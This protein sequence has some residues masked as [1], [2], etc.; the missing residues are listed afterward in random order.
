M[1][2]E[3]VA[4]SLFVLLVGCP[5]APG[6]DA[7]TADAP[8]ADART[9]VS[10]SDAP[11]SDASMDAGP[12][13][14]ID[15]ALCDDD[16]ACDGSETCATCPA[17]CGS[18]DIGRYADQRAKYVDESCA[19][20]GDGL[21]DECA[22]GAGGPG[23]FNELQAAIDT[24]VA[25]DTLYIHPGDYWRDRAGTREYEGTYTVHGGSSGT[26]ERP[27]ILTAR[28]PD[29]PPTI[30]SCDPASPANCPTPALSTHGEEAVHDVIFDHLRIRGR[31]QLWGATRSVMQHL[32]CSFGWG[33]CGDGNW[34]CLR[35]EGS[36]DCAARFNHVHDVAGDS[37]CGAC[38]GPGSC[39]GFPDRGSGLKEFT[40]SRSMWE[41]NTVEGAP[42]WGYDHHRNSVDMT[43]RFNVFRDV[44]SAIHSERGRNHAIYGNVILARSACVDLEGVNEASV[45]PHVDLVH[46]N[47]CGFA[48]LAISIDP[49]HEATIESN[50][51]FS[52]PPGG[53]EAG[54]VNA[55]AAG[56]LHELDCNAYDRASIYH[57]GL[58][59]TGMRYET[60]AAWQALG[61]DETS[62]D[63]EGGACTFVDP[64][65]GL[66]DASFDLHVAGGAC[67]TL[68]CDGGVV[69]VYGVTD[70]VGHRCG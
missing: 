36:T 50:A 34:A 47:T 44:G 18:C 65:A 56:T 38:G 11:P 5:S 57:A 10:G 1:R 16:G 52:L 28:F 62:I 63:A 41:F 60:L 31:A 20:M 48:A 69:G 42:S 13:P 6:D 26:P 7:G 39:P 58:Y 21:L 59:D 9:D 67:D 12:R 45:G 61:V 17:E 15:V 37:E 54:N 29:D 46:H 32:E 66:E 4:S 3:L 53:T 8:A 22:T 24:L 35:I 55:A 43:I 2:T 70:C 23:R 49:A 30:H 64:P 40:S 51:N 33:A 25:G 19:V 27:V 14:P 68:A